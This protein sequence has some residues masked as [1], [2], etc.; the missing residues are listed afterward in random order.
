MIYIHNLLF[1]LVLLGSFLKFNCFHITKIK[2]EPILVLNVNKKKETSVS[3]NVENYIRQR[4]IERLRQ[5]G[6]TYEEIKAAMING[7]K[8]ESFNTN[9]DA[10]KKRSS[11]GYKKYLGKGSLDSRLRA[12][13]AY[14]R[15]TIAGEAQS[16]SD[17][18]LNASDDD[19]LNELME[20]DDGDEDLDEDDEEALYER[21]IVN[22]IEQN[23][24][25]ELQ[26][27]F[28]LDKSAQRSAI[29]DDENVTDSEVIPDN[30]SDKLSTQSINS[31]NKTDDELYTPARSSWGVFQRP[32]DISKTYG[33]GRVISR[34]EMRKMDE[35][36][37]KREKEKNT[38][39]RIFVNE[40]MRTE[41][42]NEKLIKDSLQ[43]AKNLMG[44]GNRIAAVELL[45]N[46]K[47]KLSWQ[48]DLGG[49][50]WLE[51]AMALETVDRSEDARKIY[52]QLITSSWN[53][54]TRRNALSLLQGLDI[55][56]KIRKDL[57]PR[58]PIVDHES[59]ISI[60][61]ALKK[62]LT[63]EWDDYKKDRNKNDNLLPWYDESVVKD[64]EVTR[65][66]NLEDAYSMLMKLANPLKEPSTEMV[67]KAFRKMYLSNETEKV[68][69]FIRRGYG[70][71][72]D[73]KPSST[74]SSVT[75]TV[76]YT[77]T[78]STSTTVTSNSFTTSV[79]K[80]QSTSITTSTT[81]PVMTL[82]D[83]LQQTPLIQAFYG[84]SEATI[85]PKKV[86][87]SS[88]T[89]AASSSDFY[90]KNI[91]GSW[92]LVA[93]VYDKSPYRSYRRYDIDSVIRTF[94][95]PAESCFETI[96]TF[97]GISSATRLSNCKWDAARCEIILSGDCIQDSPVPFQDKRRKQQVF[98][99][100]EI[101]IEIILNTKAIYTHRYCSVMT[102]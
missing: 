27:N 13:V 82:K 8:L 16:G 47:D 5:S 20:S 25:A 99:V 101:D 43:R 80:V 15:S 49:E 87:S 9:V 3:K 78:T 56:S 67:V 68:N 18:I 12:I 4:D 39:N 48:S 76:V 35:D 23:K 17:S 86:K 10:L 53:Q 36:F 7:T 21:L 70:S 52:G 57:S 46:V 81:K 69:F 1:I 85:T 51:Y 95:I 91:N 54:K 72:V 22:V 62:G 96:P 84:E 2:N 75:S 28:L 88:L 14:K 102:T 89:K 11:T 63:N 93:S 65:I 24:L 30:N 42:Q 6:A 55:T 83:D 77:S 98:Q 66:E 50:T 100:F 29:S 32:K 90:L 61:M 97:F 33:G 60:S 37:E 64:D 74:S 94:N 44:V 40:A 73:I 38:Q 59:M 71:S 79:S 26:R 92:D 19:E 41:F 31:D 34:E 45:E 58:K